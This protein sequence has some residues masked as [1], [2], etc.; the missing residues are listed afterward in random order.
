MHDTTSATFPIITKGN[1]YSQLINYKV[2]FTV[3]SQLLSGVTSLMNDVW[4]FIGFIDGDTTI[5]KSMIIINYA[6]D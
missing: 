2:I 1:L 6:I 5:N 4:Y 3:N